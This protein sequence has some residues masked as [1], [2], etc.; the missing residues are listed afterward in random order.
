MTFAARLASRPFLRT[1]AP[2]L[3]AVA[4]IA[5]ASVTRAQAPTASSGAA[6]GRI[7]DHDFVGAER[8]RACHVDAHGP[9]ER[10]AHARAFAVLNGKEQ[11]DPRCLSCHTTVPE[12]TSPVLQGVQCESC[13]GPGRY[14]TPEYVMRDPELRAQLSMVEPTEKTC[15][16]CHTDSSPSLHP[17]VYAEKREAIR[18]WPASAD[19]AGVKPGKGPR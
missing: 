18:H 3:C 10:S 12:D 11:Q 19:R 15:A 5:A 6:V 7:V 9:W 1:L 13:H 16:R 14:Y 8:C 4:L 2:P 17:F